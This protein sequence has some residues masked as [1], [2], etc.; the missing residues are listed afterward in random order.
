VGNYADLILR[1]Q[2]RRKLQILNWYNKIQSW[3]DVP[4]R[5]IKYK[6]I[7]KVAAGFGI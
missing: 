7:V 6:R 4:V 5:L 1:I 3:V 2:E